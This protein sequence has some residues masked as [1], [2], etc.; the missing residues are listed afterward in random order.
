MGCWLALASLRPVF[1]SLTL[2]CRS[3]GLQCE[4]GLLQ[5]RGPQ[6]RAHRGE[7]GG[8]VLGSVRVAGA[9]LVPAWMWV[10][11]EG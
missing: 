7:A 5:Y 9:G 4:L 3:L 11:A 8:W 6:S 10:W 1:S 2:I